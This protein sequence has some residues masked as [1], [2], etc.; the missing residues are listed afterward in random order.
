M[1]RAGAGFFVF[2]ADLAV[3]GCV[4]SLCRNPDHSEDNVVVQECDDRGGSRVDLPGL[5]F[6]VTGDNFW[7]EALVHE[8]EDKE[9]EEDDASKENAAVADD[10]LLYEVEDFAV[11][12][13][14]LYGVPQRKA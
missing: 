4:K 9:P 10:A 13:A 1:A 11:L 2:F 6:H 7:G 14:E 8:G 3:A 12:L 5:A